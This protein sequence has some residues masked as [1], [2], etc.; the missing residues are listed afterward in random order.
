ML[1]STRRWAVGGAT[2]SPRT[3]NNV[4]ASAASVKAP[5]TQKIDDHGPTRRSNPPTGGPMATPPSAPVNHRPSAKL[6]G[7]PGGRCARSSATD[8]G[9]ASA[10]P[11]PVS[12]LRPISVPILPAKAL[13]TEPARKSASPQRRMTEAPNRSARPPPRVTRAASGRRK[14]ENIHCVVDRSAP[15]ASVMDGAASSTVDWSRF[16]TRDV[17]VADAITPQ[18]DRSAVTCGPSARESRSLSLDAVHEPH[19]DEGTV[20]R[21]LRRDRHP[22]L[23]VGIGSRTLDV[24]AVGNGLVRLHGLRVQHCPGLPAPAT[25]VGHELVDVPNVERLAATVGARNR[26]TVSSLWWCGQNLLV[27]QECQ[28]ESPGSLTSR[29]AAP[30]FTAGSRYVS[31]LRPNHSTMRS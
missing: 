18:W 24:P 26:Y 9:N 14:P 13:P 21:T 27:A 3:P 5:D 12:A 2:G 16:R 10:A 31:S 1:G 29:A 19:H 15:R 11:V 23:D 6:S 7:R 22:P 8:A 28:P 4:G 25:D 30:M 17:R 20:P